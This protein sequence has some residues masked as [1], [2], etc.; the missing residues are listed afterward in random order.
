MQIPVSV[1]G[2][3]F[4][5]NGRFPFADGQQVSID[6]RLPN[7]VP[8]PLVETDSQGNAVYYYVVNLNSTGTQF[9]LSSTVG[10]SPITL[11]STGVGQLTVSEYPPLTWE[12]LVTLPLVQASDIRERFTTPETIMNVGSASL[13]DDVLNA[14]IKTAGADLYDALLVMVSNHVKMVGRSWWWWFTPPVQPTDVDMLS[15]TNK[16]LLVLD[17]LKNPEKLIR[18]WVMYTKWVMV[19]DGSWRNQPYDQQFAQQYG[20]TPEKSAKSAADQ[21]LGLQAQLLLVS[22]NQGAQKI[23]AFEQMSDSVSMSLI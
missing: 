4:T 21:A 3:T 13:N 15:T 9:Q 1:S 11:T 19:Q 14:K 17:N 12:Q 20:T 2:S 22:G 7:Q 16:A 5:A 10:G 18:A 8:S 23:F 6:S